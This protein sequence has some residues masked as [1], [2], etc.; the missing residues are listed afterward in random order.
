MIADGSLLASV[1]WSCA[2]ASTIFATAVLWRRSRRILTSKRHLE[3]VFDHVDPMAVIDSSRRI[4][5]VNKS[6]TGLVGRPWSALL[7]RPIDDFLGSFLPSSAQ[8]KELRERTLF[9]ERSWPGSEGTR[10]FDIHAV[11][12]GDEL[13]LHFQETT[14][15]VRARQELMDRNDALARLTHALQSEFEVA[16]EI[17]AGL[18]PRELPRLDG[19]EFL[20]RYIPSR[21]VGGD[22]YDV[23]ALDERHLGI[24]IA[25]VSGHGLPAAFEAALVRMSFLNRAHADSSPSE[26]LSAMNADLRRS[27]AV[28][29]Y[30][31]AFYGI[32]DLET[33][34]LAY[35]RASHPR[36]AIIHA[37]GRVTRL[38]SQGL[39]LGI[40]DA[41][42]YRD[43]EISLAQGDRI[44]LFTDGYYEGMRRDGRRL[45]YDGFLERIFQAGSDRL[46]AELALIEEE[47]L[48]GVDEE[49]G[50][51]DRTFLAMD[52]LEA[53]PRWRP[54]VFQRFAQDA[55]PLIH[56][57]RSNQESWEIIERF[58]AD[59]AASG[60]SARD[61]RKAQ[62]A[63]SELCVNSV[64]HGVRSRPEGFV[65]CAWTIAPEECRF[66]VH[67]NG[68]G[69]D[70]DRL[71]DPR[72]PE[73]IALDH[74]RGIFLVRRIVSDLW[75]DHGGT[76][77]SFLFHPSRSKES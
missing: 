32:L 50:E 43:A 48:P 24:F 1:A 30:A 76:T 69:F 11:P 22:L 47:F 15:L 29:H 60:W 33:L 35:C 17:Q 45:G 40:V 41:A 54:K 55:R 28:G 57:F 7:G 62:L 23:L 44:C 34:R 68:S 13:L 14:Q 2:A 53:A 51:D 19:I 56:T 58:S 61:I 12:V 4:L 26:T 20:V 73:R 10:V 66:S 39:F 59:L 74:G 65:E 5:R 70:P 52:V 77:A 3:A 27:L 72:T 38:A 46:S 9:D 49:N 64:T 75:Y 67:D 21:P 42:N 25:D 8:L 71:P 31:T 37:D 18:L 36:P 63:A 16:R 6:F